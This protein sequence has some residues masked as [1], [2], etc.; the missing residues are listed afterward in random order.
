MKKIGDLFRIGLFMFVMGCCAAG[1]GDVVLKAPN[2]NASAEKQ[3]QVVVERLRQ[4][5]IAIIDKSS[6]FKLPSCAGVWVGKNI[7]LTA[8][9]CVEDEVIVHYSTLD[10]YEYDKIRVAMMVGVDKTIDL[11]LLHAPIDID[12]PI[13]PLATDGVAV[14][15][16]VHIVGHPVGYSWTYSQGDI[17]SLRGDVKGPS[18][19]IEKIIQISAPVWLGNS[20]GGAF[21]TDG[22]LIGVCSWISKGGP[23]LT[24]FIHKDVIEKFVADQLKNI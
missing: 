19:T 2:E 6:I 3:Q 14:G 24:F 22:D 21:N 1:V 20:G 15:D 10:E 16:K 17:S 12:H 9:N 5:T 13:V 11:A 7:I 4:A 18:G 23:Q 8:A